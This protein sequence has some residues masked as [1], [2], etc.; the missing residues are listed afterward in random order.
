MENKRTRKWMAIVLTLVMLSSMFSVSAISESKSANVGGWG[1]QG[2]GTYLNPILES[3]YSDPDVIRVNDKYYMITST[4][5]MAP[6]MAIL[7]STD[8]V[9]WKTINYCIPDISELV[10]GFNWDS[11]GGYSY[12]G[13]YAGAL[14]YLGWKERDEE[15][16]L[17]ERHK[18]FMHATFFQQGFVVATADD[19]YGEWTVQYMKDKNGSDVKVSMWDDP[20]PYWEFNEDGT[21][22]AAY[23]TASKVINGWYVHVFKMSL[24]GTTLL[25]GD[26]KYM[27]QNYDTT[28]ERNSEG[29]LVSKRTGEVITENKSASKAYTMPMDENGDIESVLDATHIK[30]REGT[31]VRDVYTGEASKII[32]FGADTEIGQTTFSGRHGENQKVCDYVYI[33]NNECWDDGL[34]IPVISRAKSIYGDKFD[35]DGNYIGPGTAGDPGSYETQRMMLTT[36]ND[37]RPN[38]GAFVDVPNSMSTDGKE[39]WYWI[40][41]Q[42]DENAG[43]QCRP[44]SLQDV[45]WVGGFPLAGIVSGEESQG[46]PDVTA[47]FFDGTDLNGNMNQSIRHPNA[48]YVPGLFQWA[49]EKPPIKGEHVIT[50]FQSGDEFNYTQYNGVLKL[51][52]IWQWNFQPRDKFWDLTGE[53]LRLYAF[54]TVDGSDNFFK[55]GNTVC[56]RYINSDIV[57]AEVEMDVS[58]M[59]NGQKAG[60]AHFNG[61]KNSSIIQIEMKDGKKYIGDELAETDCIIFKT[62]VDANKK[63]SFAYSTDEGNTFIDYGELYDLVPA[64]YR[65]DY[66]GIFTY[67]NEQAGDSRAGYV[68]VDYFHYKFSRQAA[69]NAEKAFPRDVW[70]EGQE[71]EVGLID[72]SSENTFWFAPEGTTRFEESVAMTQSEQITSIIAPARAGKYKLYEVSD[73]EIISISD[74]W[75]TVSGEEADQIAVEWLIQKI[76]SIGMVTAASKEQIEEARAFYNQMAQS[77]K[78]KIINYDVLVAAESKYTEV[79]ATAN[80]VITVSPVTTGE[81]SVTKSSDINKSGS[82]AVLPKKGNKYRVGNIEYRVTKSHKKKGTAELIRPL[83]TKISKMTI[84]SKIIIKGYTF[85][86]TE[87]S[88]KAFYG[89]KRMKKLIIKS[90]FLKKTGKKIFKNKNKKVIVKVPSGKLKVYKK[91]FRGKGIKVVR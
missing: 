46:T 73:G 78:E 56:Q 4:F 72:S 41:Q 27:K 83:K 8:L 9:N 19:V 71:Q 90:K 68:D 57:T 30:D 13:L 37:R 34:R 63:A 85:R 76:S 84:P 62:V 59:E 50:D 58:H 67:N 61:G 74:A 49:G 75:L 25:D 22:K 29:N 39:H 77:Q 81:P 91:M 43:P 40:T 35:E 6:G 17:V 48:K 20:C 53:A 86:V 87:I 32:T 69:G 2:D 23:M 44:T 42:G 21:L 24:D 79:T 82:V 89:C 88:N 5:C 33:Y 60:F 51:N 7:E 54:K 11:M 28:R 55:I 52:P 26:V 66:I 70:M 38:Q 15:G 14:R 12:T 65:G 16:N 47:K 80:P 3:D 18:W 10:P 1:D 36:G 31:V 45:T 64:N